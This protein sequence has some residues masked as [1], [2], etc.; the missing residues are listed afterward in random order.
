MEGE[1]EGEPQAP[2]PLG[3][4]ASPSPA[5]PP[6]PPGVSEDL[7]ND[8]VFQDS[9]PVSQVPPDRRGQRAAAGGAGAGRGAAAAAAG[10][11]GAARGAA[12]SGVRRP[13]R[14]REPVPAPGETSAGASEEWA[15]A[16]LSFSR[17]DP[18][19]NPK[20]ATSALAA[21]LGG[22]Q[23]QRLPNLGGAR[24]A[25]P[26][27]SSNRDNLNLQVSVDVSDASGA[28]QRRQLIVFSKCTVDQVI[29]MTLRECK[30]LDTETDW[31]SERDYEL[32]VVDA[33][34]PAAGIDPDT[35]PLQGSQKIGDFPGQLNFALVRV[36]DEDTE[37]SSPALRPE[38]DAGPSATASIATEQESTRIPPP[39]VAQQL[40][41]AAEELS[42]NVGTQNVC[43]HCGER[44]DFIQVS[45]DKIGSLK[46]QMD[47]TG[48]W[49]DRWF[50]L[51]GNHLVYWSAAK[52]DLD[53]ASG[54]GVIHLDA[55]VTIAP[56]QLPAP[57]PAVDSTALATGPGDPSSAGSSSHDRGTIMAG[58]MTRSVM[59][60]EETHAGRK[61]LTQGSDPLDDSIEGSSQT[62]AGGAAG[63]GD[64]GA[65]P[66]DS[67]RL[68]SV[69]TSEDAV[70]VRA[71]GAFP[72]LRLP[73]TAGVTDTEF[74]VVLP[75]KT[76]KFRAATSQ[77]RDSWI[78]A[79]KQ[80]AQTLFHTC[81]FCWK[82]VDPSSSVD[83]TVVCSGHLCIQL[84]PKLPKQFDKRWMVCTTNRR[85]GS[86][87]IVYY[88]ERSHEG[89]R[90]AQGCI[91]LYEGVSPVVCLRFDL[92]GCLHLLVGHTQHM[93]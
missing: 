20:T 91:H 53:L 8:A 10:G 70:R 46:K 86:T 76:Y 90:P 48:L 82:N 32:Y 58:S 31:G 45:P 67:A 39:I 34:G 35:N 19:V 55:D 14:V 17:V 36:P 75:H 41:S 63:H 15:A 50:Q 43:K 3:V 71:S 66:L 69:Q 33:S 29:G 85:A 88:N 16:E 5:V 12:K 83:Q 54:R 65:M 77:E 64:S 74:L 89:N 18:V 79:L 61:L 24:P 52:E 59:A 40:K 51:Y 7:R 49:R 11:G 22:A 27:R 42:E 80:S 92:I 93:V 37:T 38:G 87:H 57:P 9:V 47:H 56:S 2:P 23:P 84:N 72:D 25:V 78:A 60:G 68:A 30:K 21:A 62:L 1:G 6:P 28:F 26:R 44:I 13:N 73:G 81:L 4:D